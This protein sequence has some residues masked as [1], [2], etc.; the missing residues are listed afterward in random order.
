MDHPG[1][2]SIQRTLGHRPR[3]KWSEG[4]ASDADI[5]RRQTRTSQR[6]DM[7]KDWQETLILIKPDGVRRQLVGEIISRFE[8]KGFI[9]Y[10]AR[11]L[12]VK[13]EQAKEFYTSLAHQP[14]YQ[15]LVNHLI[16]G[17]SFALKLGR[18][19]ALAEANAL[20]ELIRKELATSEIENVAEIPQQVAETLT[21]FFQPI[22]S[23]D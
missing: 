2:Y 4:P 12:W 20:I 5:G 14:V 1:L 19:F 23:L 7:G 15:R 10:E 13:T 3:I 22:V 8:R 9:L 6:C 16:S 18:E 21:L 11:V 17:P